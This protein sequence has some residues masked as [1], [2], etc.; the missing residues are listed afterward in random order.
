MIDF[1]DEYF[2]Y[3]IL[4][5]ILVNFIVSYLIE[6]Y[7]IAFV[8]KRWRIHLI[9]KLKAKVDKKEITYTLNHL[10]QIKLELE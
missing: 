2:R 6:K 4:G 9:K 3:Y 8:S 10:N 5:V 1:G 7:F